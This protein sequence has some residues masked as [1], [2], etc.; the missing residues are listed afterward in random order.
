MQN[1]TPAASPAPTAAPAVVT[2]SLKRRLIAMVYESLLLLAV[3]IFAVAV[4]MLVT[5]N[6]HGTLAEVGRSIW[7]VL[8]AGAYFTWSWMDSG[9]TLAMKT[10]R[11]KLVKVGEAKVPFKNAAIRYAAAWGYILPAL[12]II[13][14]MG[15]LTTRTGTRAAFLILLANIIAWA[16]TALL[17]K[18]RQFLHDRWAGT[19]LIELPK[20]PKK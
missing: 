9:H 15:L 3:E 4:Y 20:P 13:H 2:P 10:W 1:S 7:M 14:V 12:L 11:I 5:L 19:R 17:D 8:A 16:C 18:D 6:A